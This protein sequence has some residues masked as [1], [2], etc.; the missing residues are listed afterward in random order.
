MSMMGLAALTF[1]VF[2]NVLPTLYIHDPAVLHVAAQLLI[3]AALFQLSDGM[4][5]VGHGILRGM[6]DV[7][8]PMF[9]AIVAYWGIGIPTSY[10]L[11][12]VAGWGAE[13]VWMGFVAGLTTA[14]LSFV[15][16]FH[17]LS[18]H[19]IAASPVP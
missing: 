2:R 19:M 7:T 16:R 9:I 1:V 17:R 18:R 12:F 13:G 4:Q 8:V 11:A 3:L 6:T 5:V 15:Y 14:A 10:I